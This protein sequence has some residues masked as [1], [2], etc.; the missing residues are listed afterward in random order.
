MEGWEVLVVV[1]PSYTRRQYV[2]VAEV[3]YSS[4]KSTARMYMES[5]IEASE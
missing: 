2:G 3:S 1:I 5:S 4:S